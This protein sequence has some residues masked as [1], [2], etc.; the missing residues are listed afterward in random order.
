MATTN[1]TLK[2]KQD[3]GSIVEL[4]PVGVDNTARQTANNAETAADRALQYIG[5]WPYT[6]PTDTITTNV[7][8]LNNSVAKLETKTDE[9]VMP[10]VGT[11]GGI[12]K[13]ADGSM[14][15]R[16]YLFTTA[17]FAKAQRTQFSGVTTTIYV[18]D[19]IR[20]FVRPG[21]LFTVES[22]Y[23]GLVAYSGPADVKVHFSTQPDLKED[24]IVTIIGGYM[25]I[26]VF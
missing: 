10:M 16:I 18:P 12:V 23:R 25:T 15:C 20:M 19:S 24:D 22:V 11:I 21:T 14:D 2:Y 4:N 1:G 26:E 13:N 6:D 3:D 5:D 17:Q 9:I 8:T 7:N